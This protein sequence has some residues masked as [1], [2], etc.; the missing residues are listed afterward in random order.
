MAKRLSFLPVLCLALMTPPFAAAQLRGA[1]VT[2]QA[3]L[4]AAGGLSA[5]APSLPAATVSPAPPALAVSLAPLAAPV[6]VVPV[7]AALAAVRPAAA[8]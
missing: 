1:R 4:P 6:S 5:A 2:L 8:T 7:P 3:S